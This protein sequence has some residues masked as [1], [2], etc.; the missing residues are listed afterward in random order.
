MPYPTN[1]P[2]L[3]VKGL[4]KHVAGALALDKVDF[5]A[6][7]SEVHALISEDNVGVSALIKILGGVL[8]AD[9]GEIWV[10]GQPVQLR[11]PTDS[12]RSGICL[13]VKDNAVIPNLS[14]AENIHIGSELLCGAWVS[15]RQV[16]AS[17]SAILEQIG[18]TFD[19]RKP[20]WQLTPGERQFV[21]IARAMARK[22]RVLILHEPTSNLDAQD[23]EKML[24]VV[25]R[26]RQQGMA[27]IY[28]SHRLSEIYALSD[29]VTVLHAGHVAGSLNGESISTQRVIDF[30]SH[31]AEPGK[32][33]VPLLRKPATASLI[34][35]RALT[36]GQRI[37][38][39]SFDIAP[40]EVVGLTGLM[41]SGRSRLARLLCGADRLRS[42]TISIAGNQKIFHTPA[43]ALQAG[44]VY[45]PESCDGGELFPQMSFQDNVTIGLATQL[46]TL[47]LF[48][49]GT[50]L[51]NRYDSVAKRLRIPL[52]AGR[53]WVAE[54]SEAMQ[55]KLLLARG[56]VMQPKLL[57]WDEP[58]KGLGAETK[59]EFEAIVRELAL[60]GTSVLWI[61]AEAADIVRVCNRALVM[62]EGEMVASLDPSTG[63]DFT[64]ETVLAYATGIRHNSME[65]TMW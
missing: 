20:V 51:A 55:R 21:V 32:S 7:P 48:C 14:A 45:V 2:A 18:A 49:D 37:K 30:M 22:P 43:H 54:L 62:C 29:R 41:G 23:C 52:L 47:G 12:L 38:P 50:A 26:L 56:L 58:V 44:I 36:D 1:S 40:G 15:W 24:E 19:P 63:A 17:A 11:S 46:R 64:E 42:G 59:L 35:V 65:N 9:G 8:A 25:C 39:V 33:D 10:H 28:I 57:I 13:V 34:E 6:Y 61:S 60:N 16:L 53:S 5:A 3:E 27:I 31:V 4:C